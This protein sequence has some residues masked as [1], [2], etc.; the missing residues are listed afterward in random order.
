MKKNKKINSKIN[1]YFKF[2]SYKIFLCILLLILFNA[3]PSNVYANNVG[4]QA[5]IIPLDNFLNYAEINLWY[6]TDKKGRL[7]IIHQEVKPFT[8]DRNAKVSDGKHK[9]ILISSPSYADAY[10]HSSLAYSLAQKGFV[11]A[12]LTHI[13]DSKNN[14]K[15][16]MTSWFF[17]LRA[18]QIRESLNY[19]FNLKDFSLDKEDI[20]IISFAEGALSPLLFFGLEVNP[21]HYQNFCTEFPNDNF[22]SSILENQMQDLTS[23]FRLQKENFLT[24]LNDYEKEVI[25]VNQKNEKLKEN[26]EKRV[27]TALKRR[28]E[29]PAEPDYI[30]LPSAPT[31]IDLSFPTDIKIK[32]FFFL[33]PTFTFL[34]EKKQAVNNNFNI[35]TFYT[36]KPY[37]SAE[38]G[39]YSALEYLF[40]S[41]ITKYNLQAESIYA[42]SDEC[43]FTNVPTLPEI[44]LT[45]PE[46]RRQNFIESFAKNIQQILNKN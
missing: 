27:Q 10:T 30:S 8:I 36:K 9:L 20:S 37:Y 35:H 21:L 45:I 40:P 12:T 46:N 28:R 11:V 22:C 31:L 3:F 1:T 24:I 7:Q 26:W 25:V 2:F 23:R 18:L 13:G 5:I 43:K 44:C 16:T 19:L 15:Y 34:F 17:F 38:K 41:N 32:N 42:L 33:E 6:P 39:Q 14:M 29:P 4:Y